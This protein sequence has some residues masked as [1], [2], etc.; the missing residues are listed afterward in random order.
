[1]DKGFFKKQSTKSY[2]EKLKNRNYTIKS[3]KNVRFFYIIERRLPI[4]L[5]RLYLTRIVVQDQLQY[6]IANGYISVDNEIIKTSNYLVPYKAII[7][8]LKS[9]PYAFSKVPKLLI[10]NNLKWLYYKRK[11]RFTVKKF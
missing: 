10:T 11:K 1:M 9:I 3:R 5:S 7:R 6:L 4:V 8:V 2:I